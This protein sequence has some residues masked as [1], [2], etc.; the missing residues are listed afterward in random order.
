MN[1]GGRI[2]WAQW[3]RHPWAHRACGLSR[4]TVSFSLL[5]SLSSKFIHL[6][7]L[8]AQPHSLALV[9]EAVQSGGLESEAWCLSWLNYTAEWLWASVFSSG[10]WEWWQLHLVWCHS[11]GCSAITAMWALRWL[12]STRM[13]QVWWRFAFQT[14][15]VSPSVMSDSC[16]PMD[17]SPP[18]SSVRGILQARILEWGAISFSRR[19]SW[20]RDWTWVSCIAGR[21]FTIWATRQAQF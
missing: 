19:S 1:T 6:V 14:L 2:F 4:G 9:G 17:C 5:T 3:V 7:L 16:E 21:F 15:T 10:K 20:P 8:G 12:N 13:W 18:G 11:V